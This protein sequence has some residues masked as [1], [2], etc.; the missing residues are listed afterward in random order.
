MQQSGG[1]INKTGQN[2]RGEIGWKEKVTG[3]V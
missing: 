3:F 2:K 1:Q